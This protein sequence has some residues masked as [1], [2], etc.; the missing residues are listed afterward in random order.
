MKL[1]KEQKIALAMWLG[2]K[3]KGLWNNIGIVSE[4]DD[5]CNENERYVEWR[6][7]HNF[8]MAGKIWNT[9]DSIYVTGYSP[10]EMEAK[11]YK[12]HLEEVNQW[13]KEIQELLTNFS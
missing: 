3:V 6:I 7:I 9:I 5:F 2:E 1:N 11:R 10:C 12:K 13:N 8:G 4:Y